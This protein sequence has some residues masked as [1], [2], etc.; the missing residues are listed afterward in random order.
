MNVQ[1]ICKILAD[2]RAE[3]LAR[4]FGGSIPEWKDLFPEAEEEGWNADTVARMVQII[5]QAEAGLSSQIGTKEQDA[6]LSATQKAHNFQHRSRVQK[7]AGN[8]DTVNQVSRT[9]GIL[10]GQL[11]SIGVKVDDE[12]IENLEI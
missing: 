5:A 4:F 9:N 1:D 11:A 7:W 10:R 3:E 6:F 12:F 2:E 8:Y